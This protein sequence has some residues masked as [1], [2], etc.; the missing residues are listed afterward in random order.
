MRIIADRADY[1]S[2]LQKII[3]TRSENPIGISQCFSGLKRTHSASVR[4]AE[5]VYLWAAKA[6]SYRLPGLFCN[7]QS[8]F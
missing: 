3:I 4:H 8:Q 1:G 6:H 5:E 7:M 2:F